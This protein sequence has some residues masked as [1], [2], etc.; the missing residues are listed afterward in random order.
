MRT[1]FGIFPRLFVHHSQIKNY[2]PELEALMVLPDAVDIAEV[3]G[4][5]LTET[6]PQQHKVQFLFLEQVLQIFWQP[7]H[8]NEALILHCRDHN[9]V[10]AKVLDLIKKTKLQHLKIHIIVL[11]ALL[12]N[13][14]IYLSIA[15]REC[16][17]DKGTF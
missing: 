11:Q 14:E 13:N 7:K 1:S 15:Q 8:Y 16:T 4:L 6:T 5:K 9:D 12:Q 2:L 3:V 10:R 17:Y